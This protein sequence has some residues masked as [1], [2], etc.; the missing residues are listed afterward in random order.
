MKLLVQIN[1]VN[2]NF[3]N[4]KFYA[5][6]NYPLKI[7]N[8]NNDIININNIDG[9]TNNLKKNIISINNFNTI[10]TINMIL[11]INKN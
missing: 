6:C 3:I 2:A 9:G 8:I 4:T 5:L 10:I 7:S 1:E 11:I